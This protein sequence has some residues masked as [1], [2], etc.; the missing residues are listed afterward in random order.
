MPEATAATAAPARNPVAATFAI[1]RFIATDRIGIALLAWLLVA[2][3]ARPLLMSAH[4]DL[5]GFGN[6]WLRNAL[7]P[8]QLAQLAAAIQWASLAGLILVM[9]LAHVRLAHAQIAGAEALNTFRGRFAVGSAYALALI[10]GYLAFIWTP[11]TAVSLMLHDAFIFFDAIHRIDQGQV[12]SVD[13]PTPLGAA[14]LYLPWLGAKVSGGYAGAVELSSAWV[15]LF[16]CLACV[17]ASAQ[18]HPAAVTAVLVA[19]IFVTVVPAMLEGYPAPASTTIEGGKPVG[20]SDPFALAMFYNRWG[21]GAIIA[22]FAFLTPRP[23]DAR[24]PTAEIVT[25]GLLLVFLFWLKLSYFAVGGAV[26]VL[27]AFLGQRPWRTLAI[28]AGVTAAGILAVGLVTG[29]LIAYAADIILTGKVSGNR[30]SGMFGLLKDNLLEVL[31]A[32]SAIIVMGLMRRLTW[33]DVAIVSLIVLGSL[34]LINQNAQSFGVPTFLAAGAYAIW[35]LKDDDN[36][37]LR[38][39]A[40]VALALPSTTLILDRSSGLLGQTMVTRREEARPAPAWA[41]IPAMKGVYAQERESLLDRASNGE[42]AEDRLAASRAVAM[43]GRRQILRSGEYMQ[44][45]MAAMAEL[46]PVMARDDSVVVMDFN[47]PLSFLTQTRSAKGYWITFDD[48]RTISEDVAPAGDVLFADADHVMAPKLFMEPD[49]AVTLRNLY[50]P[51]L[52]KAYATRVETT[53]W[54]RWS[55]RKSSGGE[56]ASA[57]QGLAGAATHAAAIR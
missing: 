41:D 6:D 28:G 38:L 7:A 44:T 50:A 11:V 39:I 51:Y 37:A 47:S 48:G 14:M 21:W 33:Q 2:F 56:V 42:T 8:H 43:Y 45:L 31:A 52:D 29:N 19:A 26:A 13:F 57:P 35:R 36:R 24:T 46:K 40:V 53:Y 34:F 27:Y 12:P 49:T 20:I 25:L 30:L 16:L 1:L 4:Y 18:R 54:V 3:V 5:G 22:M 9:A 32:C 23:A 15:A 17:Q 10:V 55:G